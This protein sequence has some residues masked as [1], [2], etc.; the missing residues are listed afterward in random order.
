MEIESFS[1]LTFLILFPFGFPFFYYVIIVTLIDGFSA[2]VFFYF[3]DFFLLPPE[4][5]S[6]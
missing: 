5:V 2:S 6:V 3:I 4:C 1:N